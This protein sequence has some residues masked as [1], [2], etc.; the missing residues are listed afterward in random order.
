MHDCLLFWHR[1][2]P[3]LFIENRP[4]IAAATAA[5]VPPAPRRPVRLPAEAPRRASR[6][7]GAEGSRKSALP[8]RRRSAPGPPRRFGGLTP[9]RAAPARPLGSTAVEIKRGERGGEVQRAAGPAR[10]AHPSLQPCQACAPGSGRGQSPRASG[11][12]WHPPPFRRL[13][14][15]GPAGLPGTQPRRRQRGRATPRGPG[16]PARAGCATHRLCGTRLRETT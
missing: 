10:T 9:C 14:C 4:L 1:F 12:R 3:T 16:P 5:R 15:A 2:S 13:A 7:T 6:R 11:H 8:P